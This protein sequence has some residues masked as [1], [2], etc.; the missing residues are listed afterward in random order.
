MRIRR[1][2]TVLATL[3]ATLTFVGVGATGV[4]PA[5]PSGESPIEHAASKTAK[6]GSFRVSL[7]LSFSGSGG[8][9]V[10]P[11][12]PYTLTG[13]GAF[14]TTRS[15]GRLAINLGPLA[16]VLGAVTGGASV[17]STVD[18]VVLKTAVYLRYP[19]LARQISPGKEWLKFDATKLP[20]STTGGADLG[21]LAKQINPQQLLS[22]LRGAVSTSKV[23]TEV[24]R[25][26][27]TTH[28]RAQI[29]LARTV[30]AL[31]AAQRAQTLK[32]LRQAGL[33]KVPLDAWIDGSGY[34]RRLA[35]ST[36][37]KAQGTAVALKLAMDL[38]D[39]GTKISVTAPPA[40][41][42]ADGTTLLTELI[43]SVGGAKSRTS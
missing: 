36:N 43:A 14:D 11:G 32:A 30:S 35:T 16:A 33:T 6:A 24:V 40:A 28:Y 10:V 21:Q 34:L 8:I 15:A 42:V 9:A 2:T 20:R 1:R 39:F 19:A 22:A 38:Y 3:A 5:A 26:I 18:L 7:D 4:A 29:D 12:G 31:P 27:P 41:K 13:Q 37:V 25:G 17:P 23:G